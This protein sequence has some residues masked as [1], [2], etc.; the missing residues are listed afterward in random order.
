MPPSGT[1]SNDFKLIPGG[2]SIF[3]PNG[4][5]SFFLTKWQGQFVMFV[6]V[7]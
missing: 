2:V 5:S 4:N 7:S 3:A 1:V 6:I